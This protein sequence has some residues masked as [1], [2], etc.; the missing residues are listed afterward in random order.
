MSRRN[1]SG[2]KIHKLTLEELQNCLG[3]DHI[4]LIAFQNDKVNKPQ[5]FHL[6]N[7]TEFEYV[8]KNSCF[9]FY[10]KKGGN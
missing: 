3:Y 1:F 5:M 7:F 2:E 8:N 9:V 10:C 4:D 6:E